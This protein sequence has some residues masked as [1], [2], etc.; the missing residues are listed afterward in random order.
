MRLQIRSIQMK[1]VLW[2]GLCL[3][4]TA[5]GLVGYAAVTAQQAARETA[6]TQALVAAENRAAEVDAN[7]EAALDAA[8]TLAQA[9]AAIRRDDLPVSRAAVNAMLR[10]VV[11]A[12]PQFLGTYTAWEPDAFD[13]QDALFANTEG[14]DA[15]GRFIPYWVRSGG[16]IIREPLLDY[17]TEGIGEYYLCPKRTGRECVIDPYVYPIDGVDTLLASLVAPIMVDGRFYGIAGVDLRLTTLQELADRQDAFDGTAELLLISFNGTVAG[18]TGRPDLVGQ[19][20]QA[21]HQ[22]WE[23]D[24]RFIQAG[25]VTLQ[26]D[27][28][29]FAV[30]VP[31]R[32]GQTTT[33]WSAN[34]NVPYNQIRAAA[35]ALTW[36]LVGLGLVI[37][38]AALG[39]LWVVAGRLVAP[40]KKL[41][42]AAGRV[43]LGDARADLDLRQADE[44]GQLAQAFQQVVLYFQTMAGAA[45]RMAEG[46]LTLT[47]TPRSDQDELGQA[48]A[49]LV[50][51][52]RRVVGE[53]AA[54]ATAVGL[55]AAEFSTAAQQAGQATGQI[56]TTVQQ[57]ARG[58][59]QQTAAVTQSAAAV[60]HLKQTIDGVAHGAATQSTAVNNATAITAQL[61]TALQEVAGAV[62][63]GVQGG[64]A[65]GQ[66]AEQGAQTLTGLLKAMEAIK[67]TVGEASRTVQEMGARS[68]Q[69]GQIVDTIDEIAS[70]TNLLAL[71]A[72]IEAARA[73][74]QGRGFAVVADE[75]RK[76]AERSSAATQEIGGLIRTIRGTVTEAVASMNR[77]MQ[78]VEAGT[79]RAAEAGEALTA[80]ITTAQTVQ[81]SSQTADGVTARATRH[82]AQLAEAVRTV[83]AVA[84]DNSTATAQ[85]ARQAGEVM[86]GVT[87]IASVSEENSAAVEEVSASV[88]ETTAQAEAV[89]GQAQA[90]AGRAATLRQLVAQF[91]L[92]AEAPAASSPALPPAPAATRTRPAVLS[93]AK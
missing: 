74:E 26:D 52:W 91:S 44:I 47:V 17:E 56:A 8:R 41:T 45:S 15:T 69:V 40:I 30:F 75:V 90:L 49:H 2:A 16:T 73:G 54:N 4:L 34:L 42:T 48:M 35:Q 84:D 76:L 53:V 62:Q 67:A 59:Q 88:E 13:G 92:P 12:N 14:H 18:A 25:E 27:E 31:I 77:G 86:E 33:P 5:A 50:A 11:A 51:N 24:I 9:L 78:T 64:A 7:V 28:G 10:E 46:D 39:L 1:I 37:A 79:V 55:A 6:Q 29:R 63:G 21:Y 23:E 36:Q 61:T 20:M 85:M 83:K 68:E 70:Q 38:A 57:V 72:A 60:D 82:A 58:V 66:A 80:I 43:A 19:P 93:P 3:V 87:S 22:D 65:A 32:F 71:N 81:A 89:A